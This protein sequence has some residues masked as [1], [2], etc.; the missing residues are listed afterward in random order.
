MSFTL[1]FQQR[2]ECTHSSEQEGELLLAVGQVPQMPSGHQGQQKGHLLQPEHTQLQSAQSALASASTLHLLYLEWKKL[3][4]ILQV[5]NP[6][7]LNLHGS[8]PWN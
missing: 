1:Q 5:S 2:P 7:I 3:P 4:F 8:F 6:Y